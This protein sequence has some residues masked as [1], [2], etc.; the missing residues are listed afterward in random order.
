MTRR[1]PRLDTSGLLLVGKFKPTSVQRDIN[2]QRRHKGRIR[3]ACGVINPNEIRRV[4]SSISK[5]FGACIDIQGLG[6]QEFLY[7]SGGGT[8]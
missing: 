7:R 4:V 8:L 5:R 2:N 3:G 6:C 1:F